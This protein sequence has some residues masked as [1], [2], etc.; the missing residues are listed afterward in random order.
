MEVAHSYA[1]CGLAWVG[2]PDRSGVWR[3]GHAGPVKRSGQAC[4][5]VARTTLPMT[6]PLASAVNARA[7]S[8]SGKLNTKNTKELGITVPEDVLKKTEQVIK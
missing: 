7:A 3:P 6:S 8:G 1:N 4:P 5:G 2:T